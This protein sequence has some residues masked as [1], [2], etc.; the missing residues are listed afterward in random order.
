MLSV[1]EAYIIIAWNSNPSHASPMG[2]ANGGSGE[3]IVAGAAYIPVLVIV[4][5]SLISEYYAAAS[6][7]SMKHFLN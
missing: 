7:W 4:V 2:V 3:F 6:F 5:H 1:A